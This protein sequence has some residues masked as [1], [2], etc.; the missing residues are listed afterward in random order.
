MGVHSSIGG[1]PNPVVCVMTIDLGFDNSAT[2]EI[3]A[4]DAPGALARAFIAQHALSS[5]IEDSLATHLAEH[6]R[7]ALNR[8]IAG[9]AAPGMGAHGGGGSP[10][11][12]GPT[13]KAIN[14]S[15]SSAS[16]EDGV[17]SAAAHAYAAY[18]RAEAPFVAPLR[19]P[20]PSTR[21]LTGGEEEVE[22]AYAALASAASSRRTSGVQAPAPPPG[23]A[24]RQS[25]GSSSRPRSRAG[26]SSARA[27]LASQ[28]PEGAPSARPPAP[29]VPRVA[30]LVRKPVA[31]VQPPLAP[32]VATRLHAPIGAQPA[33]FYRLH[34]DARNRA[35]RAQLLA[36]RLAA[37]EAE[38]LSAA[39][40]RLSAASAN[41]PTG[42]AVEGAGIA[43]SHRLFQDAG[44]AGERRKRAAE[45]LGAERE[46]AAEW[47]CSSCGG[48][49]GGG[50]SSCGN[51]VKSGRCG[52][53][54]PAEGKPV[55]SDFA[56]A[57]QRG[58]SAND[59]RYIEWQVEHW[60]DGMAKRGVEAQ[61]QAEAKLAKEAPFRP[62]LNAASLAMVQ[63]AR[64]KR[65]ASAGAAARLTAPP[66]HEALYAAGLQ[67]K[68]DV[69]QAAAVLGEWHDCTFAPAA[70]A[71]SAPAAASADLFDRLHAEGEA[72][73]GRLAQ[74][75]ARAAAPTDP[76]REAH[77]IAPAEAARLYEQARTRSSA[78]QAT[79]QAQLD[80]AD[81]AA[82]G[83]HTTA[84][85]EELLHAMRR[86]ALAGV[87]ATLRESQSLAPDQRFMGESVHPSGLNGGTWSVG[88]AG[89]GAAPGTRLGPSDLT[90]L[91]AVVDAYAEGEGSGREEGVL[92]VDM[93]WTG[94]LDPLLASFVTAALG[95]VRGAD[96][97]HGSRVSFGTFC[98]V[99]GRLLEEA[100]G[101]PHLYLLARKARKAAAAAAEAAAIAAARE[102]GPPVHAPYP[103]AP[104]ADPVRVAQ[105]LAA[106]RAAGPER[107]RELEL[108]ALRQRLA[109]HPFVPATGAGA[110]SRPHAAADPSARAAAAARAEGNALVARARVVMQAVGVEVREG[111]MP[112]RPPEAARVHAPAPAPVPAATVV[113]RWEEADD[114]MVVEGDERP[115][116]SPARSAADEND[117]PSYE[118][119]PLR[120]SKAAAA[121]RSGNRPFVPT[122]ALHASSGVSCGGT[123]GR[124]PSVS[125]FFS[126][127]RFVP[128]SIDEYGYTPQAG[129]AP[130]GYAPPWA[131]RGSIGSGVK[132]AAAKQVE[133]AP[134]EEGGVG[135]VGLS[136]LM[137]QLGFDDL[138]ARIA[139]LMRFSEGQAT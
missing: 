58:L 69:D 34:S 23:G 93:V 50:L 95:A 77:A 15:T 132:A 3:G 87:F 13:G 61:A 96:P 123:P 100:G 112:S 129:E 104:V 17:P 27:S 85:S 2:I 138:D 113:P 37:A 72:A 4:T 133:A 122:R 75:R 5:D 127:S 6:Q 111:G 45:A 114:T 65:N 21:R 1:E 47:V 66:V 106:R 22:A 98:A 121:L 33:T 28:R 7:A 118:S 120:S 78:R 90:R 81:A 25:S 70:A 119:A 73:A 94:S 84:K 101:G 82:R 86:R 88:S 92:D 109:A 14:G 55:I 125:L 107:K 26:S 79:L 51:A 108:D 103:A 12:E 124:G 40:R 38:E 32:V 44:R 135:A 24:R 49:N 91:V 52:A 35:A 83:K 19:L 117:G 56:R 97:A 46:A 110:P 126:P 39:K 105:Q 10:L 67:H 136:S 102:A 8:H 9:Y 59:E 76:G 71:R 48:A 131:Q 36:D 54:R 63:A 60:R 130:A 68:K 74:A 41:A 29:P 18:E 57:L 89:P 42:A 16:P 20:V 11:Y 116:A 62:T 139:R 115:V 31:P 80:E 30:G 128:S 134:S 137:A 64:H 43:A 53:G 99:L